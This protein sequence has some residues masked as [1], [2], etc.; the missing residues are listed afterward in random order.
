MKKLLLMAL[1]FGIASGCSETPK[2]Y[3]WGV[4]GGQGI[5]RFV[6]VAPEAFN[7][8]EFL[9]S[10]IDHLIENGDPHMEIYC[11]DARNNTPAAFPM[12]DSQMLHWRARYL[13]NPNN[14]IKE[15]VFMTVT[16]S[17]SSPPKLR[18]VKAEIP[19]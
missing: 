4:V 14:G 7:D 17:L 9:S 6:Y 1:V 16:D 12:T 18:E 11:F 19:M 8:K 15:F 2:K 3:A 10:L 5:T 13:Q